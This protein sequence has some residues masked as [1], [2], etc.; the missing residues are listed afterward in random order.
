MA[1]VKL[2]SE[3]AQALRLP[4][5]LKICSMKTNSAL[6]DGLGREDETDSEEAGCGPRL[7]YTFTIF[8]PRL[9]PSP[10]VLGDLARPS[11]EFDELYSSRD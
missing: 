4:L 11:S 7:V 8:C 9:A 1:T 6:L 2:L 5:H 3:A 10:R